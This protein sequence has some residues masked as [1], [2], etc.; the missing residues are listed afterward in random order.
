M[1]TPVV[2]PQAS[3]PPTRDATPPQ[4]D[5]VRH[6]PSRVT[7]ALREWLAFDRI[8]ALYVLILLILIFSFWVPETF[9]QWDTARQILNNN[10]VRALAALALV[11]P[12]A[13]GVFDISVPYTMTLSGVM[14]TYTIVNTDLPI[15]AA[16]GIAMLGALAVGILNGLVV[17]VA[18]IQSLIGTLATGFL[19]QAAV[20]WRTGSRNI[21]SNELTEQFP[22]LARNRTWGLTYP[23]FY[24]LVIALLIWYFLEYTAT[25]RRH[26]ATGFNAEA[27]RLAGV[28]TARLQFASLIVSALIAGFA[29]VVLAGYLGS[30]SPTAG[31][32]YLLPAFAAVFLGATQLKQ[33]RFNAWGTLLAIVLLGTGTTGLAL[34]RQ[35]QWVQDTFTGVV[36]IAALALTSL[37]VRKAGA[38]TKHTGADDRSTQPEATD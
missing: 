12:M 5:E 10:S 26:Y 33:G 29:G 18:K 35:A 34:A 23:V 22:D 13:T 16:V 27:S 36:L 15:W 3:P 30:G 20:T 28:P 24:V 9:P 25:G 1:P 32:A 4:P 6:E 37:Q 14:A 7:T 2:N 19:I 38:E 17:V 11:I 21:T 8:G 31:N